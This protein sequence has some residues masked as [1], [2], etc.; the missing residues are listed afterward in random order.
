MLTDDTPPDGQDTLDKREAA[1]LLDVSVR[2]LERLLADGPRGGLLPTRR[3]IERRRAR[4]TPP[5]GARLEPE[6]P[7]QA[8]PPTSVPGPDARVA[9]PPRTPPTRTR[10]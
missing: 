7:A 1:R 8:T 9:A 3:S 2:H 4:P 6:C 5:P 10:S